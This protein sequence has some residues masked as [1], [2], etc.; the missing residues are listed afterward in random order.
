MK[1][2][3]GIILSVVIL[4]M[5][6]VTVFA[7][8]GQ[9]PKNPELEQAKL[10]L[11]QAKADLQAKRAEFKTKNA[12]WQA[13]KA[14]L[15]AKKA[16]LRENKQQNLAAKTENNK[17]RAELFAAISAAKENGTLTEEKVAKLAEFKTKLDALI[18]QFKG[19]KGGIDNIMKNNKVLITAKD[20]V[21]LDA[22]FAEIEVIQKTR[23]DLL[24]QIN[25]L[26]TETIAMVK[27]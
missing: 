11:S 18:T 9:K 15:E 4:A 26:L 2:L 23:S 7:I 27:A 1:K 10:A 13:Y 6:S 17:L 25:A 19:T 8:D 16:A 12:E 22:A 5:S 24:A 21:G 14:T 20:Y 3:L